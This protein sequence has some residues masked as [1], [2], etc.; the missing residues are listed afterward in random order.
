M[1]TRRW[2]I[3]VAIVGLLLSVV[4]GARRLRQRWDYCLQQANNEAQR[5]NFFRSMAPGVV[6]IPPSQQLSVVFDGQTYQVAEMAAECAKRKEIYLHAASRP[7]ISIPANHS[8]QAFY[9]YDPRS[10]TIVFEKSGRP[11][12]ESRES[13]SP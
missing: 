10:P 13:P 4:V 7:W 1:T 11:L 9:L 12:V 3:A 5:E 6:S 2:M 8:G